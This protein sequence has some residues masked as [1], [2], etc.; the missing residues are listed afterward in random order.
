M[1]YVYADEAG[2]FNFSRHPRASKY[3]ILTTIA[4]KDCGVAKDLLDL[5][6]QLAWEGH[7]LCDEGFHATVELQ[8]VR[9]RVFDVIALHDFRID[10]TI[11]EKSKADPKIRP[12]ESL[13]GSVNLRFYQYAW[14]Y[15]FKFVGP[16]VARGE[17]LLHVTAASLGTKKE[18]STFQFCL[19]DVANQSLKRTEYRTSFWPAQIDPCLQL[20][21]YC[22]WAIQRKWE[23]GDERSYSL[24]SNKIHTEFDIFRAGSTHYY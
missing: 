19:R 12:P 4:M 16:S 5:R 11:I 10:A 6:R 24:I 18:R 9:D 1:L 21:D 13:T 3:F 2:D 15:H 20:A 23:R 22:C 8:K 14:Y 7:R 17:D